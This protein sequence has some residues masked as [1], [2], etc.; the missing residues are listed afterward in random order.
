MFRYSITI[1][2]FSFLFIQQVFTDD[3]RFEYIDNYALNTPKSAEKSLFGLIQYLTRPCKNEKEKARVIFS[4][5]A[6]RITYNVRALK[7]R[8]NIDTSPEAVLESRNSIC[9][10]YARLFQELAEQAGLETTMISG[11]SKDYNY[12]PG[13]IFT[14]QANHAWNAIKIN[15]HWYLLDVTW[16]AGY[17]D[18]NSKFNRHFNDYYFFTPPEE[19]I[20]NHFPDKTQWQLLDKPVSKKDFEQL[21][22]LKSAFFQYG[23]KLISHK[24]W[25]IKTDSKLMVTFYAKQNIQLIAIVLKDNQELDN[26]LTFTQRSDQSVQ[27]YS[28]FPDKSTFILRIFVKN[29]KDPGKYQWALDYKVETTE[30]ATGKIGFPE[31]FRTFDECDA[32]VFK[33]HTQYLKSGREISFKILVPGADDVCIIIKNKFNPLTKNKELFEGKIKIE[34]GD[35]ILA[36]KFLGSD[37]YNGLLKYMGY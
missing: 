23:L 3:N 26:H 13:S 21:A 16:G 35:N 36:A 9:D 10:G 12:Q 29:K 19:F 15:G 6:H 34:K 11:Y 30:R 25:F 7:K 1:I 18:I 17:L 37:E 24:K 14:G 20:Y 27:I 22:C 31:K 33:P 32:Y 8:K 2:I 28:L 4:W 5:I